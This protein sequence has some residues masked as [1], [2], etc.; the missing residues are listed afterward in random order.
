MRGN[1]KKKKTPRAP[2]YGQTEELLAAQDEE[3]KLS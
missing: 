3:K 2:G 1:L